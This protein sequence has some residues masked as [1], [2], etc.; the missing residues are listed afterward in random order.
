ME[1]FKKKTEAE[2]VTE[3]GKE[4][5]KMKEILGQEYEFKLKHMEDTFEKRKNKLERD[6]RQEKIDFMELKET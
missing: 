6:L 5:K 1:L 4:V 3:I 2:K